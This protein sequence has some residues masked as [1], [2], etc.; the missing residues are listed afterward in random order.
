MASVQSAPAPA[1]SGLA[2]PTSNAA[3]Q[4]GR[5]AEVRTAG[6]SEGCE[7]ISPDGSISELGLQLLAAAC[8]TLR[9]AL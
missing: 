1:T 4:P 8:S 9:T 6:R 3:R 2:T 5:A 7:G